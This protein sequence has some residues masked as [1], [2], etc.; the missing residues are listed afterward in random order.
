MSLT[1]G[2]VE[3]SALMQKMGAAGIADFRIENLT[4]ASEGAKVLTE[5]IDQMLDSSGAVKFEV[6]VMGIFEADSKGEIARWADYFD[7][8]AFRQ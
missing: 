4:V 7:P 1:T 5:R 8:G 6:R 2:A 3:S